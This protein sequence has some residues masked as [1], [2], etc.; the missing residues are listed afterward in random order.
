MTRKRKSIM[1][2]P[3]NSFVTRNYL[4]TPFFEQ[5]VKMKESYNLDVYFAGIES[6]PVSREIMEK[7]S[8]FLSNHDI[9]L[10]PLVSEKG[11][12]RERFF[13]KIRQDYLHK[14]SIYRFNDFNSFVTHNRYKDITSNF[15]DFNH[16]LLWRTDV[17]PSY[18]GFPF[19]KSKK[20]LEI[21]KKLLT[22]KIISGHHSVKKIMNEI[23]PDILFIGDSQTPISFTYAVYALMNKSYVIGNVRTW[24]HL[25]KN[26]PLIPNLSE[27][28]VWSDTMKDEM[29]KFHNVKSD[30]IEI[31]GS[32]QFDNYFNVKNLNTDSIL[33]EKNISSDE[34]IILFGANRFHR[35]IGEPS[36]AKHIAEKIKSYSYSKSNF[37]LV[38]RSHPMDHEFE[39]RFKG[40]KEYS[41]VKLLK[42]PNID[43]FDPVQYKEDGYLMASLL[44]KSKMLIC[45]QSTLAIDAS[46]TNTPIIN[47]AFEGQEDVPDLL[48]VSNRYN[49]NHYQGLLKTEGTSLV[50]NFEELDNQ[51]SQYLENPNQ[52][53]EGRKKIKDKFAGDNKL[54]SSER[55][56]NRLTTILEKLNS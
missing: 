33:A 29:T 38:I 4:S 31:V 22:S 27:Y 1:F 51:I 41:F 21:M 26:G 40:L 16:K 34:N 44:G 37:Q 54:L 6:N 20:I 45:G 13:W 14:S 7:V 2:L 32:P 11:Y 8:F 5:L 10:I 46:C 36:I 19:P 30:L 23:S 52:Y 53:F 15:K 47:L 18:L 56:I 43:D 28:W 55:I 42:T 49:V 3:G 50:S 35:G 12:F 17:W 39:E 48:S 9:S 25:T 24:D